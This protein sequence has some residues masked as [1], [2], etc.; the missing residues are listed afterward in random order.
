MTGDPP[1]VGNPVPVR[2]GPSRGRP[3]G[4]GRAMGRAHHGREPQ[5]GDILIVRTLDPNLAPLLPT[6]GGLVAETGSPLSHLAILAREFNVPTVVAYEGAL[7]EFCE[8]AV[9]TV[10]GATGEVVE[11]TETAAIGGSE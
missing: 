1:A 2:T 4:G 10:D 3:A 8:G 7:E 5:H 11:M 9:L 6:I